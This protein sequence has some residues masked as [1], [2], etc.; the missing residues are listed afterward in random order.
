MAKDVSRD[1]VV[2]ALAKLSGATRA[3][4]RYSAPYD[5]SRILYPPTLQQWCEDVIV[6][7]QRTDRI[8]KRRYAS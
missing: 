1:R 2:I 7:T 4:R 3:G 6:D 8:L 5:R